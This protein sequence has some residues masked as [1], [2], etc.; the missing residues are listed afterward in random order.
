MRH[1]CF[2]QLVLLF[3]LPALASTTTDIIRVTQ[4][5]ELDSTYGPIKIAEI[6]YLVSNSKVVDLGLIKVSWQENLDRWGSET[7]FLPMAPASS[8]E[9]SILSYNIDRGYGIVTADLRVDDD[10]A[11]LHFYL[12]K[13][14]DG[15]GLMA[16]YVDDGLRYSGFYR[17]GTGAEL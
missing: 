16:Y 17:C 11:E 12:R 2:A 13:D 14:D 7:T 3:S 9:N 6:Q 10:S 4:K 5:C 8:S 15:A 1:F